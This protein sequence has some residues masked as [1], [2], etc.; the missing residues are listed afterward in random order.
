MIK[1]DTYFK[2][3]LNSILKNGRV[4]NNPRPK[5]K[6]GTPAH[7]YF[8]TQVFEKYDISN[9]EFPITTLKHTPIKI[10]IKEILW[11]YQ[12][13]S[14]SLQDA[15]NR[16]V[17]WWHDWGIG[18]DT[19]GTRYGYTVARWNLV[20]NL[21][22]GLINNPFGRRHI[23]NLYQES[24]L[25]QTSGLYPCA[26]ETLWSVECNEDNEYYLN[27]TLVQRSCDYLIAGY[28]NKIQYVALMMMI[29]A[30]TGYKPGIFA[31]YINNL[32]IYDRHVKAA[33]QVVNRSES[34]VQPKLVLDA[35]FENN[36][37]YEFNESH[38]KLINRNS[39][40]RI[41]SK[42]EIAV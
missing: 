6:D 38:F 40:R 27:C 30:C 13:Q 3:N 16:G 32:H 36:N 26:Y 15:E 24:D 10:G 29:A 4:D 19:I 35:N 28:V 18:D 42:P 25:R 1:S 12:D 5:Y 22:D 21:I 20:D 33:Q 9:N 34:N 2:Q 31:H 14:H 39:I 17:T 11:I 7:T 23:M 8:I 37:F 41:Q